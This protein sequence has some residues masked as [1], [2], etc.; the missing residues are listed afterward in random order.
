[1]ARSVLV[2]DDDPGV[3]VIIRKLAAEL[4]VQSEQVGSVSAAVTAIEKTRYA[5]AMVDFRLPDGSGFDVIQTISKDRMP[6]FFFMTA[7]GSTDAGVEAMNKGAFDYLEKPIIPSLLKLKMKIALQMSETRL[8]MSQVHE[9]RKQ[10]YGFDRLRFRSKSMEL[11]FNTAK[12]FA[13]SSGDTLL[14]TGKA[15]SVRVSLPNSFTTAVRGP[16]FPMCM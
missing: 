10:Y 14:I 12:R 2:I 3:G 1:M 4:G 15:A 11:V 8:A 5:L 6:L 13:A 7:H 16:L 9:K